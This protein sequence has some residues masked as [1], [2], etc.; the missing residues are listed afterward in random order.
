MLAARTRRL[1]AD[2]DLLDVA[3]ADGWLFERAGAGLAGRGVA[4]RVPVDRVDEVLAAIAV[5][6]EVGRPGCGPIAFGALPFH[7]DRGA[8]LVIPSLVV[9]TDGEGTRWITTVGAGPEAPDAPAR[10]AAPANRHPLPSHFDVRTVQDP[11]EWCAAVAEATNRI[12]AGAFDKVV[13]AR[14]VVVTTDVALRVDEIVARLRVAF[15]GCYVFS[16]DGMVGASPELLVSR[17][18]DLVRAQPMAG[19]APRGGDPQSDAR[20]AAALLASPTY[21]HEHQVTI[22]MVHDTLLP[23][24]SYLDDEAEPSVVALPNVSH[25]ATRVEGRLS[26]PAASVLE[27]AQALHPT[28]AVCG[29]PSD[30]ARAAI[31]ELE[32]TPRDRYAGLVGWVDGHGNGTWAVGIRCAQV[33]GNVAR[34]HGGC[35]IVAD[36]DPPTELAESRA[37]LQAV[38]GAIVRP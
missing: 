24:C 6:D 21:R 3:G 34:L 26:H 9:G 11:A 18:G 28:P 35:G 25:L 23:F 22:D 32:P 4:A 14:E 16:V 5:D 33:E 27:L 20:L 10:L 19:T 13:L 15:A 8:E 12:R 36:S 31:D 1:D 2:V 30:A 29:R 17:T 7:P 38:L 37:K